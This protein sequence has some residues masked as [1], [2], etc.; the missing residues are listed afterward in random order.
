MVGFYQVHEFF[1]VVVAVREEDAEFVKFLF[2]KTEA[3]IQ[4]IE[5]FTGIK[6]FDVG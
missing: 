3:T 1:V 2:R 4:T 6:V 5:N